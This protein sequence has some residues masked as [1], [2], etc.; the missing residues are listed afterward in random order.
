M[1]RTAHRSED[2]R[3]LAE[4][5]HL[6]D[7]NGRDFAL[8]EADRRELIGRDAAFVNVRL[9]RIAGVEVRAG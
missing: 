9:D 8:P 3:N 4:M 2:V 7:G 1:R 6:L 5:E